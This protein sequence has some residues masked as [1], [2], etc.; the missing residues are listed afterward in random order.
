MDKS[1]IHKILFRCLKTI[2]GAALDLK[3]LNNEKI[4]KCDATEK[5]NIHGLWPQI[6]SSSYPEYCKSVNYTY[7]T[8]QLLDDMKTYWH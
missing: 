5:F 4:R 7:P 2:F 6:N 1:D 8:D 3:K